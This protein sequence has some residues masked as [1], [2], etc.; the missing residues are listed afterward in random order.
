[1]DKELKLH[2]PVGTEPAIFTWPLAS[3]VRPFLNR[4]RYT[5]IIIEQKES[6]VIYFKLLVNVIVLLF[7]R[8]KTMEIMKLLR[9]SGE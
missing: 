9:R 2:S 5:C 1:M 8:T 7:C 3:L 6:C 4:K